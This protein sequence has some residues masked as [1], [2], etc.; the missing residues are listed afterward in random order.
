MTARAPAP[1]ATCASAT[2]RLWAV[3]G[4]ASRRWLRRGLPPAPVRGNAPS[5]RRSR[6]ARST[7][8]ASSPVTSRVSRWG[9]ARIFSWRTWAFDRDGGSREASVALKPRDDAREGAGA[10]SSSKMPVRIP[11]TTIRVPIRTTSPRRRRVAR[12]ARRIDSASAFPRR[13]AA[14]A[15]CA[16]ALRELVELPLRRPELFESCGV[17]PPRGVLLGVR[18]GRARRAS[19]A[20]RRPRR[21]RR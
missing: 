4:D 11:K 10:G 18:P 6:V 12:D 20:R 5:S 21:A 7:S 8:D 1:G 3:E 14:S 16:A 19:R 9:R 13:W 15:G 2:L 17:R